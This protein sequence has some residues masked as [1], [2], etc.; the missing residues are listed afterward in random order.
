MRGRRIAVHITANLVE[1]DGD[2]HLVI[3]TRRGT[4]AGADLE[5]VRKT[6]HDMI[7]AYLFGLADRLPPLQTD[8]EH[9]LARQAARDRIAQALD[10]A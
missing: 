10:D 6:A 9:P 7:D 2:T 4:Q 8:P 5:A 1:I 3:D